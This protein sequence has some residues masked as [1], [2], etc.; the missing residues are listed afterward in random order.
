MKN[1]CA[2]CHPPKRYPGC[3][4]HCEDEAAFLE[5]D[6]A[7]RKEAR[8]ERE[9]ELAFTKFKVER[10]GFCRRRVGME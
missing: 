5:I 3:H 6:L 2:K 4:G 1:P 8:A 9:K 10:A 7:K